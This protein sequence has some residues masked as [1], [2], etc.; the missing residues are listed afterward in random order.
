MKTWQVCNVNPGT[1]RLTELLK[2]GW[3]PFSVTVAGN[4]FGDAYRVWLRKSD[5]E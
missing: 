1:N 2:E 3:E 5:S 4:G